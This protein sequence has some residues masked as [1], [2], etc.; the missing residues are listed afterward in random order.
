MQN[1]KALQKKRVF[2]AIGLNGLGKDEVIKHNRW[3][4]AGVTGIHTT[5]DARE[6]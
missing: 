6:G 2:G 5:E 3:E 1:E 4:R